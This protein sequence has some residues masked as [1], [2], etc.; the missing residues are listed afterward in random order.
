MNV[1][2]QA[3]IN[4]AHYIEG[5]YGRDVLAEILG[6]CSSGVR[7]RCAT[8]IAIEWHPLAELT[9]FLVAMER[10]V[11]VPAIGEKVGAAGARANTRGVMLRIAMLLARPEN[12]LKRA[13]T[14][15]RQ[16]ND[17]GQ[18]VLRKA[19]DRFIEV[20]ITGLP[21]TPRIFCDTITGWARELVTSAGGKNATAV[22]EACRASGGA[23]CLWD[24]RWSGIVG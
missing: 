17:E 3:L 1:K 15:W 12:A 2:A 22:H 11:A 8:G 18:L 19:D 4:A 9:E 24:V 14:M 21:A 5:A 6:A 16:F 20:E 10:V 7:D 23:R 13:A